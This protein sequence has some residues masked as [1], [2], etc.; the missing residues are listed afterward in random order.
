[1]PREITAGG[2]IVRLC[3]VANVLAQLG[4]LNRAIMPDIIGLRLCLNRDTTHSGK[5]GHSK[6]IRKHHVA[7]FFAGPFNVN[8]DSD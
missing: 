1:M 5:E 4:Y 3:N 6:I 2:V 7:L 8:A